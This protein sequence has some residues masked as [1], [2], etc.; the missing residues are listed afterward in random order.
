MKAPLKDLKSMQGLSNS[1]VNDMVQPH[2]LTMS[3]TPRPLQVLAAKQ[4]RE[5]AQR[6]AKEQASPDPMTHRCDIRSRFDWDFVSQE[7][8]IEL[9]EHQI[10]IAPL[11]HR[12]CPSRK[13][14]PTTAGASDLPALT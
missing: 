5:E 3:H 1:S 12:A 9:L 8:R 10:V 7:E 2:R 14:T 6:V 4:I 13:L 11:P